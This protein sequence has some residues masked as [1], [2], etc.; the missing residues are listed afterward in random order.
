MN[1]LLNLI[2]EIYP[3]RGCKLDLSHKKI[4]EGKYSVCLDF[5]I[6]KCEG[7]CEQKQSEED[8]QSIISEA[9]LLLSGKTRELIDLLGKRMGSLAKNHEFE[10]AQQIKKTLKALK[11]TRLNRSLYPI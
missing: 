10:E 5:H 2:S 6:G 9:K 8:Y 11:N 4:L 7:P 3:I 1:V